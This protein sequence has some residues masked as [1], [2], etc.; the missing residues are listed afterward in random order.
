M[1]VPSDKLIRWTAMIVVPFALLGA[2]QPS[3]L[4]WTFI[5]IGIFVTIVLLDAWRARSTLRGITIRFP[6]VA[7]MSENRRANLELRIRN[8]SQAVRTLRLGLALPPEITSSAEEVQVTLPAQAEWSSLQCPCLPQKRGSFIIGAI[9]LETASS[10]GFWLARTNL[11]AR[12]EIRVYPNL[13]SDRRDLAALFLHRGWAGAHAQRQIGKGRDFEKLREY[14]PG[15]G[16]DEIHWKATARRGRPITKVFQIERT[17]EIYV[18]V[19]ASRLSARPSSAT[20]QT[21]SRTLSRTLSNQLPALPGGQRNRFE[22]PNEA[23]HLQGGSVSPLDVQGSTFEV[24]GSSAHSLTHPLT[25]SL[26]PSPAPSCL[27]RYITAALVLG[28]AA[29][30]Q[31]DLFGIL[32]FTHRVE[33]FV[34]ARNGKVHYSHCRDRLYA[35]G[36]QMVSPD[37]EE[38]FTYIRLRLRRRALL[39]FLTALDDPVL[40]ESFVKN[41]SLIQRQHV[42]LVNMLEPPGVAPLFSDPNAASVDELYQRLGG[43]LLWRNLRELAK[44]LQRGAVKFSLLKNERLS[45]ELVSQYLSVKKRQLL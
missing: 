21:L 16:F 26:T 6:E 23:P 38:L 45:A 19:D 31:G 30:Q 2:L 7:R 32:T 43:H 44:V 9:S 39:V 17:Q 18:I 35:L 1:I 37:F 25:H 42:I 10:F 33:S 5:G 29:E 20:D 34:R 28:L 12:S 24:Q 36:S 4:Q 11:P 40:A 14:I 22:A 27:D 13:S 15:D 8:E 3:A 41:I